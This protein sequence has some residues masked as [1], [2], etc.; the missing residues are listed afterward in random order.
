MIS[1]LPNIK[2]MSGIIRLTHFRRN[3]VKAKHTL[4]SCFAPPNTL[5]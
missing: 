4:D 5:T 1:E 3:G 2:R